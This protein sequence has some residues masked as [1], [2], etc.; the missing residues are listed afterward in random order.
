MANGTC[1]DVNVHLT[2]TPFHT[3]R[4]C[5]IVDA[6][7][8]RFTKKKCIYLVNI[9]QFKLLFL[10]T[11]RWI[12]FWSVFHFCHSITNH[13][14]NVNVSFFLPSH[15]CVNM[16]GLRRHGACN[17]C[18]DV[19][20]LRL[21]VTCVCV[22]VCVCIHVRDKNS[23]ELISFCWKSYRLFAHFCFIVYRKALSASKWGSWMMIL[24][25]QPDTCLFSFSISNIF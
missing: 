4:I 9:D 10:S 14:Q 8:V 16:C 11:R 19:I 25:D 1:K 2:P 21:M 17:H 22:C 6:V 3:N 13:A 20:S 7:A 18:L 23:M 12:C 15:W 24:R 5:N